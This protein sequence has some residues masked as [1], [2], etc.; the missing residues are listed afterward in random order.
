M[1]GKTEFVLP[2]NWILTAGQEYHWA[3]EATIKGQGVIIAEDKFETPQSAQPGIDGNAFSSVTILTRGLEVQPNLIEAQFE[4][5]ANQIIQPSA[6]DNEGGLIMNYEAGT[7]QWYWRNSQGTKQYQIPESKFGQPLVLMPN[8]SLTPNKTGANSGFAEAAADAMFA[9]LVSFNQNL[10]NDGFFKSPMHFIGVGQGAV[11]NSEIIQR[12]G[13]LLPDAS[14][15]NRPDLMMTTIDPHDFTQSSLKTAL[16][17]RFDPE[18]TVWE[19]VTFADNYYQNVA[20][21]DGGKTETRNGRKLDAADVNVALN[22]RAGFAP[23]DTKNSPHRQATAWYA[24][25]AN[26][27]GSNIPESGSQ[28]EKIY[29]RLGDL[30]PA[31]RTPNSDSTWY[32]PDYPEYPYLHGAQNAPWE[33][34]GTGWFYSVLGGGYEKRANTRSELRTPVSFDNTAQERMRGDKAVPTLFN[35]NFDAITSRIS[36]QNIP[37]WS[38]YNGNQNT[39]QN[40]SQTHLV[41]WNN[42]GLDPNFLTG[43]G[44]NSNESNYALKLSNDGAKQVTHNRFVVPEWGTLRFDLHVP[45]PTGGNLQVSIKGT[46]SDDRWQ[47]LG[48]IDLKLAEDPADSESAVGYYDYVN[49][50]RIHPRIIRKR[51][52]Q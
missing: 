33:G 48:A 18:V 28:K 50:R 8:L 37:G 40:V 6:T 22:S 1:G 20:L 5:M 51:P 19:N 4:Q 17:S 47:S 25:T 26:L 44:Y 35:G 27:S 49:G 15:T 7:G 30:D 34:V 3:I 2:D 12:M 32:S 43:V 38:F 52:Q 10:E 16:Q 11:I 45:N 39:T 13:T 42:I 23:D 41:E 9:S 14:Q 46:E 24:G 29:R 36:R 31:E 21:P